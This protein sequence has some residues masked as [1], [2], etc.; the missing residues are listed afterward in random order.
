MSPAITVVHVSR[1]PAESFSEFRRIVDAKGLDLQVNEREESGPFA[2]VEWLVPTALI[3][4]IAKPYFESFLKEMGKD[5]YGLL[6]AGLKSLY[7]KF[8]GPRAPQVTVVS[9]AGKSSKHQPYSLLFS[10]L[11]EGNDGYKFKLLIQQPATEQEYEASIM[12]FLAFLDGFHSGKLD[13][14][15]VDELRKTRV[16]GRTVLLAFNPLI[17][18][19][20]P[21]D[22]L[23]KKGAD[24]A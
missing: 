15:L 22:P 4:Y 13:Q 14:P 19:V 16:V 24:G 23:P 1:I 3:V 21:V 7:A 2:A 20:Q 10:L 11:A 9:T 8:V 6:K 12:A 17:N 5:H 18:R